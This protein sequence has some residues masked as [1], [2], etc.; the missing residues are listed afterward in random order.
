[1]SSALKILRAARGMRQADLAAAAAVSREEVSHLERGRHRPQ[2]ATAERLAD[3][4]GVPVTVAFP[5]R[6]PRR[7][8]AP[9]I[10]GDA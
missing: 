4:L 10:E 6:S 8:P 5:S 2:L 3:A 7:V 9:T 1:M